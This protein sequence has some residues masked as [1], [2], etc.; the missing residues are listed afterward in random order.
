MAGGLLGVFAYVCFAFFSYFLLRRIHDCNTIHFIVIFLQ[1]IVFSVGVI[2]CCIA[3]GIPCAVYS[4]YWAE[5]P[6][7]CPQNDL[8]VCNFVALTAISLLEAVSY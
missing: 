3:T 5:P 1:E 7:E 2:L 4:K 8:T 6:P